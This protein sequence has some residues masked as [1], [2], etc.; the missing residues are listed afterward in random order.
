MGLD[1][2]RDAVWPRLQTDMIINPGSV[3]ARYTQAL[4]TVDP[5]QPSRIDKQLLDF[6]QNLFDDASARRTEI[7]AGAD[8]VLSANGIV[9]SL[10]VGIGIGSLK[11]LMQTERLDVIAIYLF[12]AVSLVFLG[13]AIVSAFRVGNTFRN[14]LGPDDIAPLPPNEPDAVSAYNRAVAR[15]LIGYTIENYKINNIERRRLAIAKVSL[16][17]GIVVIIVGGIAVAIYGL[18]NLLAGSTAAL[19]GI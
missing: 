12:F 10:I 14:T 19:Q 2:I 9:V 8:A 17:N 7:N 3:F 15:K 16:R 18:I 13:R 1:A 6:A 11:D 5:N 4:D